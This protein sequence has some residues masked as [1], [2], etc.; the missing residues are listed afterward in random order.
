MR[1]AIPVGVGLT[2][3]WFDDIVR[4]VPFWNRFEVCGGSHGEL[5]DQER[6]GAARA[7]AQT[8]GGDAP[9]KLES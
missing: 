6:S 3:A 9:A 1:G 8:A 5:D 2:E 7:E 4:A